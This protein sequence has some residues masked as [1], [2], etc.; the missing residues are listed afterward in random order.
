MAVNFI[1][2]IYF[3]TKK[4]NILKNPIYSWNGVKIVLRNVNQAMLL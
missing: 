4:E 2:I 1:G 3:K